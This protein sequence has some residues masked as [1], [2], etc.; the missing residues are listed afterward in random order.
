M[1]E[2]DLLIKDAKELITL[3][4]PNSPRC[5]K[6]LEKLGIIEDGSVAIDKGRIIEV[7]R[8]L[9][10]KAE[11]I[12]DAKNKT[13][14]PGFVDPHT[15]LVFGGSREFEFDWKLQ[16]LSYMQ[17]KDRGGGIGYTV[18]KTREATAEQ[19]H[20][21][22]AK[23]LQKML[24]YGTT[25]LEAK[26]GYGLD[27][28]TELKLLEVAEKLQ[29]DF[30]ADMVMTF[31]GAHDVPQGQNAEDYLKVVIKDM[32]PAVKNKARFCDVF[33]EKGVFSLD[34]SKDLLT[35][36]KKLGMGLKIHADEIVQTG[37]AGLA[38][39]LGAISADH[40]LRSSEEDMAK[41]AKAGTI[42]VLLPGTPFA[43]R[44][45]EYAPAKKLIDSGVPV[46][47][48]TDLNPNCWVE[49]MQFMIQ[50]ACFN[51]GLTPA[52]AL[53]AATFNSACAIDMQDEVGSLEIGKKADCV[54]LDAPNYRFLPY[55]FGVNLAKTVIKAGKIV[56]NT[57]IKK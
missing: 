18:K 17:I 31:L 53:T 49:S 5:K 47:L 15:H 36:A 29:Q 44:M 48:A 43:L 23:R 54:I 20:S 32:L 27:T 34:Q 10:Y 6:D 45:K 4:G 19:L 51:M 33:C 56:A 3:A 57:N 28:K 37:G 55:H 40:L 2:I 42:G 1:A 39:D 22:A 7:G 26:T 41:M 50:L 38:A 14:I 16:G 52:Q 13:V 46:A 9:N 12:I 21:Q 24:E 35:A 25:T 30:P 11:K 8:N